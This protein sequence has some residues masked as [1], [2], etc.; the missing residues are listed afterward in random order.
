[1]CMYTREYKYI[2]TKNN[3]TAEIWNKDTDKIKLKKMKK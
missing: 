1:M 3:F 2:K